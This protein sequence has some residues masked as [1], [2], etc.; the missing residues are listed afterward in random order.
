MTE[1]LAAK[2]CTACRVGDAP[3]KGDA[4]QKFY[5]QLEEG[6]DM[7]DEHH[8]KKRYTFENFRQALDFTNRVGEMAEEQGHHPTITLTWGRV[9]VKVW[10]HKVD[11]LTESDFIFAA[12]TDRVLKG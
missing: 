10:T 9:D 2:Q 3:L 4:L 7:V 12:K 1:P 6:W 11:G 8:L 5:G